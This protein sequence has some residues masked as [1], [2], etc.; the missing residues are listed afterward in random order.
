M[1]ARVQ[2]NRL[3]PPGPLERPQSPPY[4]P[5]A[6]ASELHPAGKHTNFKIYKKIK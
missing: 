3:R 6:S 4:C 2:L 5:A 1:R